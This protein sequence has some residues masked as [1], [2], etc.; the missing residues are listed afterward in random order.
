MTS[1]LNIF[2]NEITDIISDYLWGSLADWKHYYS[3]LLRDVEITSIKHIRN[4]YDDR[5]LK[6]QFQHHELF[7]LNKL[8]SGY[9]LQF[10]RANPFQN[11]GKLI[12]EIED[13]VYCHVC[14]E[15]TVFPFTRFM[16]HDCEKY[17]PFYPCPDCGERRIRGFCNHCSM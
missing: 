1:F 15:K 10:L 16:C 13:E 3:N 7:N 9:I 17:N 12:Y 14:G 2:P 5:Y 4:L 11:R 8:N 6:E